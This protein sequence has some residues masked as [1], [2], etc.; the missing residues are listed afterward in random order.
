MGEF[1]G[2]FHVVGGEDH[3]VALGDQVAQDVDQPGLGRVVQ[4]AGRLVQQDQ[5]RAGGQDD[6]QGER[7]A[8]ALGEVAG[9]GGVVDARQQAGDQS[10]AGARFGR[11][12]GV[13][14]GALGGHRVGRE[15]VP[16]VLRHQADMADQF[17]RAGPV[18]AEPT[19]PD[20]AGEGLDHAHQGAEQGGLAGAVAAHQRH[21]LPGGDR[22]RHLP[23]RLDPAPPY[24]Q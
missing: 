4:A 24:R 9:V 20:R 11:R 17:L 16:G 13:G 14:G 15:Q 21:R 7:E 23:Q 5:R 8:L 18:R 2:Q 3:R 22:E 6:R 19:H 1:G 10:P 12:V